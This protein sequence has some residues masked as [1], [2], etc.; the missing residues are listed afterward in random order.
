[1]KR[2]VAPNIIGSEK[3]TFL[4][5]E[6]TQM[7][8]KTMLKPKLGFKD[9][10]KSIILMKGSHHPARLEVVGKLRDEEAVFV[11]ENENTWRVSKR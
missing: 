3:V 10:E 4:C 6:Q 5:G 7:E 1:M 9:Q 11:V 8:W 2:K